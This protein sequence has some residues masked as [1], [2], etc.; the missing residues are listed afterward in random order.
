[1]QQLLE[2]INCVFKKKKSL[3]NN[4]LLALQA[5]LS[6]QILITTFSTE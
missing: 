1:M 5:L 2:N 3:E 6:W 4:G